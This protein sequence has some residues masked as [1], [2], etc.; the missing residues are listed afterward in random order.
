MVG[1]PRIN[2]M[3]CPFEIAQTPNLIPI[4]QMSTC[5]HRGKRARTANTRKARSDGLW[6]TCARWDGGSLVVDVVH[7]GDQNW[8]DRSG[9]YHSADMRLVERRTRTGPEHLS[10][11]ATIED[12]RV[13]SR[14]WKI[15]MPLDRR[16]EP[17]IQLLDDECQAYLEAE[18]DRG[19]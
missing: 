18:K 1:T 4:V 12:P 5:I 13:F 14:P 6:A 17:N 19:R 3:P 11:E 8:L 2:Y 9:T 10:Y 15:R 16:I 7:F